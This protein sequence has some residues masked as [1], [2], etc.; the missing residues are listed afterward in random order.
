MQL[1]KIIQARA[2]LCRLC[3][4]RFKS[5]AVSRNLC[6][7]RKRVD[8]EV[9]FFRGEQQKLVQD[10]ALM[11]NGKPVLTD[12]GNIR[13][14]DA[15]AQ[16]A[17]NAEMQK[18]ISTEVSDISPVVVSEADFRSVEDYPTPDDMLALDG[19]VEFKEG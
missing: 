4:I 9:E 19:L 16:C 2:A 10:Y 12:N 18:L 13:L 5:F 7:L 6:A 1:I 15:A 8:E 11:E 3:E 14:K 17:Y